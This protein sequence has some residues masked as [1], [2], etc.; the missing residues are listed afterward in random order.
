[1]VICSMYHSLAVK[2]CEFVKAEY[3]Q[4]TYALLVHP[5]NPYSLFIRRER[6][7]NIALI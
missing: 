2:E 6:Y 1:M 4:N 3:Y 5:Q 7:T